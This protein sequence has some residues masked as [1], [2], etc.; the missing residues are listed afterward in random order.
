MFK[1]LRYGS[2]LAVFS[3]FA[4]APTSTNFTL[5]S[6]DFGN[7]GGSGASTNYKIDGTTG[8]QSGADQSSTTYS[9]KSGE[10]ATQNANVPP[11]ASFTN[12]SNEYNR[13]KLVINIG[14]NPTDVKFQVAISSD[15]FATT[16]YVQND[17]SVGSSAVLATYQT[18]A[19]WGSASGVWVV[20]L[21]PNVTYQVKVRALQ[22][23]FSGS[24]YGP[25]ASA[26]TVQASLTF[27]VATSL[28]ATPPYAIAFTSLPAST[29][30]SGNATAN[31]GLT[32]NA[33]NGG[34]VYVKS[35]GGLT[36]ASAA[37]TI[38]SA[39]ANLTVATSGYG[40]IIATA[41]Q[42]SGGPLT[43]AAPFSGTLNNV[44][45]LTTALQPILT[46]AAAVTTGT[47]TITLKAKSD[48]ITPSADDYA[49]TLT[50]VAGMQY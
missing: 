4:A 32:T 20:G 22:G 9:L 41:T 49:D 29:V 26:S 35:N 45:V 25:T 40:A 11:A 17:N 2:L 37:F 14:G 23:N 47:S 46:T 31:I 38:P 21:S 16:N 43:A 42:V 13:L 48:A 30:V 10:I 44:G 34:T 5:K 18:Y 19:S 3:L 50:F 24:P 39:T 36:S 7:G 1:G 27:S 28:T 15:S 6:Y 33:L 8:T 12:P